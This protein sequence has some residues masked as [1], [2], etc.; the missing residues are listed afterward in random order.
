MLGGIKVL[1]FTHYLQGPAAAQ[2][3]ADLGADVVKI[4]SLNGAYER[5]W[6]GSNAFKR[7]VSAFF[8]MTHRNQRDLAIDLKAS[9][10]VEVVKKLVAG[11]DVVIQNFRIGVMERLGMG[12]EELKAV[13]PRL[14][15]CCCS[16]EG[17]TGPRAQ[18]AGQDLLAQSISGLAALTGNG[19]KPPTPV[20][21]S[22]VDQHGAT[23]ATLG[24]LAALIDRSRTGNGCR[25][26]CSLLNAA[27]DLQIEAIAYYLN[28]G[29]ITERPSTGLSTRFHQSPY[30]VYKTADSCLTVSLTPFHKLREAFSPG[31]LDAFTPNDQMEKRIPFDRVVAAELLKRT[32][33]KWIE[34][35]T[36]LG[37]WH[38]PVLDYPEVFADPQV[39]HNQVTV[40]VGDAE[41]GHFTVLGH[42]NRYNGK[43]PPVRRHPPRLGEHT[44][45]ILGEA[46]YSHRAIAALYESGVVGPEPK[47]PTQ[48]LAKEATHGVPQ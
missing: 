31:A 1:S 18:G 27:L 47:D 15:Y 30:G 23:L 40:E 33:A 38:A 19:D 41:T 9:G 10:A 5:H 14:I 11:C 20:G 34:T 45:E 2:I 35:F 22:V 44:D 24:I 39:V 16:G 46:G 3:L 28:D 26:D 36:R 37:I 4:E 12:Y 17:P 32:T 6:A 21:T 8:M 29:H 43:Y 42:P 13:N 25:V 48:P 7:G